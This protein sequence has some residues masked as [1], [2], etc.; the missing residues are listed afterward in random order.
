MNEP[1]WPFAG[2]G[3]WNDP[4]MLE[5]GNGGLSDTEYRAHFVWAMMAAPLIAGNDVAAMTPA[6]REILLNRDVIAVD[7]DPL[8]AQGH[9]V[10]RDGQREVWV[11]PMADGGR[12]LLFWNR[13]DTPR[14]S[15]RTG[16]SWA[17]P[18]RPACA[19][20]TC[21]RTRIWAVCPATT[22]RRLRRTAWRWSAS[23]PEAEARAVRGP[24]RPRRASR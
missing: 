24:R 17:C 8:G 18:P 2:P 22:R 15:A 12:A 11:K 10:A 23:N 20:A 19:H 3:H 16:R 4:D 6:T 9:R 1:L 13:G 7:Q 14:G 5:V 21:G